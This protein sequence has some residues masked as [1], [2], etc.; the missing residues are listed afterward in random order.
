[1]SARIGTQT[2]LVGIIKALG[3]LFGIVQ[4]VLDHLTKKE[5]IRT[6]RE[7]ERLANTEDAIDAARQQNDIARRLS[8]DDGYRD[9]V[10][11][12]FTRHSRK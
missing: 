8:T 12:R 3:K 6:G 5:H 2:M 4:R 9:R 10:R 1:M 11:D 7:R